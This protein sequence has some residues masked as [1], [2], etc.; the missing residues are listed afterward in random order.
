MSNGGILICK[1]TTT[2]SG[3]SASNRH[4]DLE[5]QWASERHTG[6]AAMTRKFQGRKKGK[7]CPLDY[8]DISKEVP[9][10]TSYWRTEEG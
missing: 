10:I 4:D 9:K 2:E 7:A 1:Q 8:R 3:E 6:A 5:S